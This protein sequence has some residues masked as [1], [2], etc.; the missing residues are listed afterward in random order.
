MMAAGAGLVGL[1]L[2]R[3][4]PGERVPGLA[5]ALLA[6]LL[7]GAAADIKIPYI[8]FAAAAAW[9]LR[10][11]R[12]PLLALAGSVTMV[13]VPSYLW[14]G[15]PAIQA[16]LARTSKVTADNFYQLF[17]RPSGFLFAHL[18]WFAVAG[19]LLLAVLLVWRL[20]SAPAPTADLPASIPPIPPLRL[21]MALSC[22]WLFVWPYQLPWY[23]AM[24]IC[25]L[26]F[27]PAT[28][29]DWIVL[30]RLA[31]GT[32][33]LIPGNPNLHA[34]RLVDGLSQDIITFWAPATLLASVAAVVAV[35]V[36]GRLRARRTDNPASPASTASTI[37][38]PIPVST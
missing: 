6:G 27:Y 18:F 37:S 7:L 1:L 21:A 31:A 14:F 3:P 22:A 16:V 34:G 24:I 26:V 29:L 9:T 36:T 17:S 15:P 10:R 5:F 19:V 33:A 8:I 38:R 11:H 2:L 12:K 25:L 28:Q 23:D 35:V 13:L 20:P 30:T 32:V 4:R